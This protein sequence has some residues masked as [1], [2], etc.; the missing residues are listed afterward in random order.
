[1]LN[2]HYTINIVDLVQSNY[3]IIDYI[4]IKTI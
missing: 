1:M 2:A 3:V 4:I